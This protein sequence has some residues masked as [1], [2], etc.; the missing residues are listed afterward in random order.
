[1]QTNTL[2]ATQA[3]PYEYQATLHRR[4]H[5]FNQETLSQQNSMDSDTLGTDSVSGTDDLMLESSGR[6]DHWST[7]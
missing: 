7:Y 1:M 5:S 3:G 6:H 2:Q 4:T